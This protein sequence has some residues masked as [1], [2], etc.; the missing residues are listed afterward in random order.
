MSVYWA[1]VGFDRKRYRI[2]QSS[3][4]LELP[5]VRRGALKHR[6]E[7]YIGIDSTS[8]PDGLET[9]LLSP[10]LITFEAGIASLMWLSLIL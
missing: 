2:C 1:Q 10:K 6:V 8:K 3:G 7:V 4:V 9:E 5:L